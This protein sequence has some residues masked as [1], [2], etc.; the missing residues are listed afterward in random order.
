MIWLPTIVGTA[1]SVSIVE[2]HHQLQ[3]HMKLAFEIHL[4]IGLI[5]VETGI[6]IS[7]GDR[8]LERNAW[9]PQQILHGSMKMPNP[10]VHTSGSPNS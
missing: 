10:R 9:K 7:T 2:I 5:L 6:R 8:P 1:S 3:N 4:A